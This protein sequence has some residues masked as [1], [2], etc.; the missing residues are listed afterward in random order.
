MGQAGGK[1]DGCEV[2]EAKTYWDLPGGAE[3][4][5]THASLSLPPSLQLNE[6]AVRRNLAPSVTPG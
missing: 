6:G 4:A 2:G 5:G 3:P 1:E